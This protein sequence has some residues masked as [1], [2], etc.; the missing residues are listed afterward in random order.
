M[1]NWFSH[2]TEAPASGYQMRRLANGKQGEIDLFGVVGSYW[3]GIHH[4]TFRRDLEALGEVEQITVNLMTIG[5]D[6]F[7]GLPIYN[8]LK[9]HP[10]QVTINVMGYAL[11]MGSLIMLAGDQINLAQNA[12]VMIHRVQTVGYGDADELRKQAAIAEKHEAAVRLIYAQRLGVSEEEVQKLLKAETWYTA[13]EAV[14]AGLAD[15]ITDPIDVSALEAS[16]P[17]NAWSQAAHA[18][19]HL[20]PALRQ[21]LSPRLSALVLP[22]ALHQSEDTE[23]PMNPEAIA[24]LTALNTSM[25]GLQASFTQVNEQLSQKLAATNEPKPVPELE[26]LLQGLNELKTT[27]QSLQQGQDN[28]N[29]KL[30][31]L[32][33]LPVNT[34]R[35]PEVLSAADDAAAVP[36]QAAHYS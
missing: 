13:E 31:H 32:E 4:G 8:L 7:S 21:K 2:P 20:P 18:F 27:V 19:Q 5:G 10:A 35:V 17:E 25:Q 34:R 30:A 6:F 36:R 3:D 26:Q 16:L 11:S 1:H 24:A 33:S 29:T 28:L 12:L 15:Q 23:L 22:P 14:A 9:Q